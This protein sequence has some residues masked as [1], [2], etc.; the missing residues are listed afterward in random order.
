MKHLLEKEG[1][2]YVN[3]YSIKKE[4]RRGFFRLFAKKSYKTSLSK[5]KTPVT[6]DIVANS[7]DT[8]NDDD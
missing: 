5:D 8:T 7:D 1:I 2:P 4:Q 6:Y 3:E